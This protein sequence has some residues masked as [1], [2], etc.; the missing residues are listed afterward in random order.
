MRAQGRAAAEVD[1]VL[2]PAFHSLGDKHPHGHGVPVCRASRQAPLAYGDNGPQVPGLGVL[3]RPGAPDYPGVHS[4]EVRKLRRRE[5][6]DK[7]AC[8]HSDLRGASQRVFCGPGVFY[9]VLFEHPLAQARAYVPVRR[10][11]RL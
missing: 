5:Q 7:K 6:G 4:E 9:G 2:H 8:N 10:T 11:A 3:K 1:K